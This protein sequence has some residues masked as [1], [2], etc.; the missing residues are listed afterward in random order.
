MK[1]YRISSTFFELEKF[2]SF[3]IFLY[4]SMREKR[5][6]ALHAGSPITQE[7]LDEWIN[8]EEKGAYL[9]LYKDD[10]KEFFYETSISEEELLEANKF[11]FRM[12]KL[13]K[14]RLE[15][16]EEESNETFL[17]KGALQEAAMNSDFMPL[18]NKVKCEVLCFPLHESETISICTELVDKL[19]VRDIMP[20]RVAAFSYLLA[21]QNKIVDKEKLS[22]IIIASLVKDLGFGLIRSSFFQKFQDL[23]KEDIYLKHPMLSIYILSKVGHEFPK[24]LK[25]LVLEQHEQADGSGFPREKKEDYIDYVSFIINLADQI[26]MYSYGNLNG[27]KVDLI[28][29]IEMFHKKVSSDGININFPTRLTDSLGT[30]LLNDLEKELEKNKR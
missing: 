24:Q 25:R 8:L 22:I 29:T 17:L 11:Y 10:R 2:Y 14:D 30:L 1:F 6:V 28:K 5:L 4:D 9:Q 13:Q 26:L 15:K 19:F 18:I 7:V 23:Q 3:N 27:R 20:V 12:L 16:Y 21:K